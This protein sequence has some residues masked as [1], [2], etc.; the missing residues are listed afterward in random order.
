MTPPHYAAALDLQAWR[1]RPEA[2]D[3]S[4]CEAAAAEARELYHIR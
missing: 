4:E 3:S 1:I 2:W